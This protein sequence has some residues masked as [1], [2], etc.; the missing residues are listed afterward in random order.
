MKLHTKKVEVKMVAGGVTE[1]VVNFLEKNI[2]EN[3]GKS[4]M[5]ISIY[6]PHS[7]YIVNLVRASGG[8][9]MNAALA[10]FLNQNP[11]MELKVELN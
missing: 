6:E 5:K 7:K 3:P 2:R 1:A 9:T 10:G 11:S 8:V 4:Q